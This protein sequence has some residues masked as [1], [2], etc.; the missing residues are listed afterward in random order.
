MPINPLQIET[1]EERRV[2]ELGEK[3][4]NSNKAFGD[5]DLWKQTPNEQEKKLIHRMWRENRSNWGRCPSLLS[6]PIMN[7]IS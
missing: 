2:F 7:K 1:A 6:A 5:P 4:Y 3:N